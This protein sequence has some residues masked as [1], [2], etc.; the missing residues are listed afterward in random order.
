M[1]KKKKKVQKKKQLPTYSEI[2]ADKLDSFKR[3]DIMRE[4]TG[5]PNARMFDE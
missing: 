5:K 3:V 1:E 4:H 2:F